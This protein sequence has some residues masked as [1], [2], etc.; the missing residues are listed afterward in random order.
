MDFTTLQQIL[1]H[2]EDG[3]R[4]EAGRSVNRYMTVRNWLMGF[5][6]V[7]FEQN[8]EDRAKYGARLIQSLAKSMS[9]SGLSSTTLKLSKQFYLTYRRI[10]QQAFDT[11]KSL[12]IGQTSD[13]FQLFDNHSLEI[14]QTPAQSYETDPD[15]LLNRL[16]FSHITLILQLEEP[17]Q[18][19]F[20]E[21]ESIKGGWGVRELKRQIDSALFERTGLSTDKNALLERVHQGAAPFSPE[22]FIRSPFVFEFLGI[23]VGA[24]I[25]E[26]DLEKALLDHL[27]L[28]LLELGRGFCFEA[29]QKRMLI[30]SE[31]YKVD[32][33][34]YHRLLKCHVLIDLKNEPFKLE[35]A[36][37]MNGYVNFYKENEQQ[38]DDNPPIGILLCTAKHE[39]VVR[40]AL[41]GLDERIFVSQYKL[42]LPA[43]QELE[44]F[45]EHEK[46]QMDMARRR[47]PRKKSG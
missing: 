46:V 2:L 35:H 16:S 22:D 29:R 28:F 32:L 18:R 33:V 7:E 38:T 13:Q 27:Q 26:R 5:Y 37:Q 8:G 19:A 30:G 23:P 44:A 45:L 4:L 47:K 10:G 15:L 6:I 3:F 40:F 14:G 11:L 25:E 42:H 39:T 17:I 24:S 36:G 43:E 41:G 34:F 21:I 1:L 20:Y 31:W 9:R 12:Q